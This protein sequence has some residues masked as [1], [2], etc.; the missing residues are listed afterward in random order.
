MPNRTDALPNIRFT[1]WVLVFAVNGYIFPFIYTWNWHLWEPKHAMGPLVQVMMFG[2][3][4]SL[5]FEDFAHVLKKPKVVRDR[6]SPCTCSRP[7]EPF[8]PSE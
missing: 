1:L 6:S 4:I 5:T 3:R 2:M 8:F 7:R